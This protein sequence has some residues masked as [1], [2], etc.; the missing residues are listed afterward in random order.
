MQSSGINQPGK[1][2][3]M[4]Y[5]DDVIVEK[6][7]KALGLVVDEDRAELMEAA[8]SNLQETCD[9]L[10]DKMVACYEHLS[11][12]TDGPCQSHAEPE[13]TCPVCSAW[14]FLGANEQF[15][16]PSAAEATDSTVTPEG[17]PVNSSIE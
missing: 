3:G 13:G 5:G 9:W 10:H 2:L 1:T 4:R 17:E 15:Q 14:L 8:Y 11:D 16:R 6:S 12:L 7:Q